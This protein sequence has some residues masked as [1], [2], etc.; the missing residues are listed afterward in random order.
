MGRRRR[1]IKCQ[2]K[3]YLKNKKRLL[4]S[5]RL[6]IKLPEQILKNLK[7]KRAKNNA[8]TLRKKEKEK[9]KQKVSEL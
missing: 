4:E 1:G 7:R 2:E 3:N 8:R 9:E 5:L 6:E